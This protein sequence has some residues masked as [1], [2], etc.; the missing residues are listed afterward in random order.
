M[1]GLFVEGQDCLFP[2]LPKDPPACVDVVFVT[3]LSAGPV[4]G[5]GV[6]YY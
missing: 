1:V 4:G 2:T 5:G 3:A 6:V